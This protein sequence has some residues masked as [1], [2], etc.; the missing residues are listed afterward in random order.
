MKELEEL[1]SAARDAYEAS[2]SATISTYDAKEFARSIFDDSET[3]THEP[4]KAYTTAAY[5]AAWDDHNAAWSVY[6]AACSAYDA[7]RTAQCAALD[8]YNAAKEVI[9]EKR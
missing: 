7:A 5:D 2:L 3:I 4:S 8:A 9:N 1:K 6:N